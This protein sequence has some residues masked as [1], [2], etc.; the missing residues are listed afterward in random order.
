MGRRYHERYQ[1]QQTTIP[2]V[3]F[4]HGLAAL[5]WPERVLVFDDLPSEYPTTGWRE[6]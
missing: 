5:R 4:Q 3:K 1:T 6:V 2:L